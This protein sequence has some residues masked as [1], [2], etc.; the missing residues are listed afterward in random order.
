MTGRKKVNS[1]NRVSSV[2]V[3]SYRGVTVLSNKKFVL[4]SGVEI[5]R[6]I[7]TKSSCVILTYICLELMSEG[8]SNLS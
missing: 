2:S 7:A 3:E 4:L 1:I 8:L 6:T 5:H